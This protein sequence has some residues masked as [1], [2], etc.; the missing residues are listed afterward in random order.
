LIVLEHDFDP[1][2]GWSEALHKAQ[3]FHDQPASFLN[4]RD[5]LYLKDESKTYSPLKKKKKKRRRH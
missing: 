3:S 1:F 4:E 2:R 5:V